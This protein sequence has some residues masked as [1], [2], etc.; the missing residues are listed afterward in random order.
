M[1][2]MRLAQAHLVADERATGARGEQRAFGLV[3]VELDLEQL[4]QGLV[5]RALGVGLGQGRH[6]DAR[7]RGSARR[8]ARH[9]R[10]SA[11][12][13]R[14]RRRRA[15]SVSRPPSRSQGRAQPASTSNSCRARCQ[16]VGRAGLAGAKA[17]TPRAGVVEPD[18][19][20]FGLEA[21]RQRGLA[22]TPLGQL[23][24]RELDV[25]AGAQVVGREVGAAAEVAAQ[26]VAADGHA[27]VRAALRVVHAEVGE[28]RLVA[29]VLQLESLL[30]AE[31]AAQRGLPVGDSEPGR[32][33]GARQARFDLGPSA[34]LAAFGRRI[35]RVRCSHVGPCVCQW[36]AG[37]V[38]LAARLG[39]Q[40]AA[41]SSA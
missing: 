31:L 1:A 33:A 3:G 39:A 36:L 2:W 30:A 35:A 21:A 16:H 37:D 15:A 22:A 29:Q 8:T 25:L 7:R 38:I 13:G 40:A 10:G 20:V 11:A 23:G 12:R 24:Q 17:H 4:G 9:R 14:P 6:G 32:A 34:V 41:S 19:A 28:H 5:R 26:R 18:L 27:V